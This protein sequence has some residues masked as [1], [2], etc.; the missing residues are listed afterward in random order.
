MPSKLLQERMLLDDIAVALSLD[1]R[2]RDL[3]REPAPQ[4][5]LDK[6]QRHGLTIVRISEVGES[7]GEVQ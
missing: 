1:P 2:W 4:Q 7:S 3:D 5:V 6:L